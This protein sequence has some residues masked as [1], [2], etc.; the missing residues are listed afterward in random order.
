MESESCPPP[1]WVPE[2]GEAFVGPVAL[3]PSIEKSVQGGGRLP[4]S[5]FGRLDAVFLHAVVAA[6]DPELAG[7]AAGIAMVVGVERTGRRAW[8]RGA[9]VAGGGDLSPT[10]A[11]AEEA[12]QHGEQRRKAQWL[13]RK[14]ISI[15]PPR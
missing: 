8:G 14:A 5:G 13:P 1:C 15:A 3:R 7:T 12:D 6:L 10:P 4:E 2:E 11:A 9:D